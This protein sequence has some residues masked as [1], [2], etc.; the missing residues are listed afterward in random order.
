MAFLAKKNTTVFQK[1]LACSDF[2]F[3]A[4]AY[5]FP[6]GLLQMCA[7][8]HGDQVRGEEVPHW[9]N[10]WLPNLPF[11]VIA[12]HAL[13]FWLSG[14]DLP[15]PENRIRYDGDRT[16]LELRETNMEAHRRLTK[17]LEG[18]MKA[19]G[20]APF[21]LERNLYLGKDIPIGGTAHQAGT[22]RF[23]TDPRS[24]VLDTDCKAHEL[25]NLYST[26][27]GF[28]PSIGAVT[29]PLPIV[30]NALRVADPLRERLNARDAPAAQAAQ[31]NSF[32]LAGRAPELEPA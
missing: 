14:E 15:L 25:D 22:L 19:F 9:L 17:K 11:N 29:P 3:G 13:D 23:G 21:L 28:L 32:V 12:D 24:S 4:D 31:G 26:D 30:A 6:L 20:A 7:T 8:T 18:I 2:Y 1:T 16:V 5:G 10:D 27:A